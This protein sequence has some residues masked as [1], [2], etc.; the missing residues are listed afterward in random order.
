MPHGGNTNQQSIA[1]V[2]P[3][4]PGRFKIDVGRQVAEIEHVLRAGGDLTR[5]MEGLTILERW[6]F[7]DMLDDASRKKASVLVREF[8]AHGPDVWRR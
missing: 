6:Q 8:A 7:D 4:R 2:K 1:S 3:E 5:S